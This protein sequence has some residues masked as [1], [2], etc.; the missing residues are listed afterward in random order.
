MIERNREMECY[1]VTCDGKKCQEY[2]QVE[3][4]SFSACRAEMKEQG[5]RIIKDGDEWIHLCPAC[6]E[7]QCG[8]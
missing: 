6:V 4:D 7:S 3:T 2:L 8:G 1:D 5:W